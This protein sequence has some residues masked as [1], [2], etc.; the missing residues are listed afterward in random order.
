MISYKKLW[1][2]LIDKGMNKGDLAKLTGISQSTITKLAK[3]ENINTDVLDKIC[4]CLGC[5][6][7]EICEYVEGDTNE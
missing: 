5:N 6:L 2:L 1:K 4:K 7:E 3:C